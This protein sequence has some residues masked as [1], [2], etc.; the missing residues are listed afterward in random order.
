MRFRHLHSIVNQLFLFCFIG[1]TLPVLVMGFLSYNK[2]SAI[3]EEQVS[4]V[5]SLTITQVG[6]KLNLFFKK[7]DDS[8]MMVLNS[9][10]IQEVLEQKSETTPYELNEMVK[11]SKELL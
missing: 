7:L 9:R 1:M 2:S 11:N 5:A 10:L 3:V 6:D 4:K 8:S